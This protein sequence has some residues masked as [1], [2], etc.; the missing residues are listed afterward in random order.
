MV[1]QMNNKQESKSYTPYEN[2]MPGVPAV[3]I[4]HMINLLIKKISRADA[5]K[6][7]MASLPAVMLWGAPGLGKSRSL[8]VEL[9]ERLHSLTG[10]RVI[11]TE[12]WLNTMAPHDFS[13]MPVFDKDRKEVRWVRPEFLNL[14]PGEDI[15]N[16]L[17]L[18]EVNTAIP[19]VMKIANQITLSRQAGV[20]RLPDNCIVVAAGNRDIDGATVYRMEKPL[21][22]RMMHLEIVSTIDSWK[23]WAI[24][25][26]IHESITGFLTYR[27]DRLNCNDMVTDGPAYPTPRTWELASQALVLSDGDIEDPDAFTD[28]SSLIGLGAATELRTYC[29]VYDKL[30]D[31][32]DIFDGKLPRVPKG[33]DELYALV[34]AMSRYAYEHRN[35]LDAI[36]NSIAYASKM[37]PDFAAVFIKDCIAFEDDYKLRL[38]GIPEFQQW[39]STRGAVLNGLI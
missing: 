14:D 38:L 6:I 37:P 33:N 23:K 9:P 25:H 2:R 3:T 32:R 13:G 15:I 12:V 4:E 24:K 8:A 35:D 30:P 26:G 36:A 18:D 39:I 16:I 19:S 7:S 21:A 28:V 22:N 1:L 31:I 20:H 17:F 29:R 34:S 11:V 27:P 10:K 5:M